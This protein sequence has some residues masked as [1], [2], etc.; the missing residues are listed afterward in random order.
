[1]YV[2]LI[3]F[4]NFSLNSN[5]DLFCADLILAH[6]FSTTMAYIMCREW[7]N[8]F[9]G[10]GNLLVC[11]DQEERIYAYNVENHWLVDGRDQ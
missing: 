10:S 5:P 2:V 11:M 3:H 7:V 8:L 1:M 9:C 4:Q 6:Y